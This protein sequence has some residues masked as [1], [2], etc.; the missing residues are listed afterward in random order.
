MENLAIDTGAVELTID[1]DPN[2]V[3]QFYP[4]DVKFAQAYYSLADRFGKLRN[5]VSEKERQINE[6][7]AAPEEKIAQSLALSDSVYTELETGIDQVF[8]PGTYKTV[9][10]NHCN[11]GMVANFFYG[12][13]KYVRA[14]RDREISRY[15]KF[16]E[17]GVLEC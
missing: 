7:Q 2:R 15:T 11:V 5:E 10:G 1:G 4:T 16:K 9:F 17:S 8:G 12:I 13:S 14:A 3:I 6:S